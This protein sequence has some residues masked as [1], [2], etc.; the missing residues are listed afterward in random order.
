MCV[1]LAA[2]PWCCD[3]AALPVCAS[4]AGLLSRLASGGLRFSATWSEARGNEIHTHWDGALHQSL[5]TTHCPILPARRGACHF[6]NVA[7]S[8]PMA[9]QVCDSLND[10]LRPAAYQAVPLL[11][12]ILGHSGSEG[13]KQAREPR[14][15]LGQVQR[16]T[17]AA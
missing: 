8:A 4:T 10:I 13:A 5:S 2:V 9:P 15:G 3:C 16:E 11:V 17:R 12:S 1:Q 14:H 7:L 6:D